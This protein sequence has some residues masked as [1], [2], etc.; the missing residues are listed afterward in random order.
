MAYRSGPL[1]V[2]EG[3]K[4][5]SHVESHILIQLFCNVLSVLRSFTFLSYGN[6]F[7]SRGFH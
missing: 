4:E 2:R 1:G 5:G 3:C 6:I 7:S